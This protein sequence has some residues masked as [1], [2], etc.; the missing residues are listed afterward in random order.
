MAPVDPT[1]PW[2]PVAP[3]GLVESGGPMKLLVVMAMG[4]VVGTMGSS[5]AAVEVEAESTQKPAVS[6]A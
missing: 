6:P 2:A 5:S 4:L 3:V 1:G